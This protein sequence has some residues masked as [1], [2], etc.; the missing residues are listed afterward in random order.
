MKKMAE[1]GVVW[2]NELFE[3]GLCFDEFDFSRPGGAFKPI[4]KLD[5]PIVKRFLRALDD[6]ADE[7]Y[8]RQ[9]FSE[10]YPDDFRRIEQNSEYL[11]EEIRATAGKI[12]EFMNE[13]TVSEF[14]IV[15]AINIEPFVGY[16]AG[17]T[18]TLGRDVAVSM[19]GLLLVEDDFQTIFAFNARMMFA[20]ESLHP[21]VTR[22]MEAP[23]HEAE[24]RVLQELYPLVEAAARATGDYTEWNAYFGETITMALNIAMNGSQDL[25]VE[26]TGGEE[27]FMLVAPAVGILQREFVGK[28]VAFFDFYPT[29]VARIA[30]ILKK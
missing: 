11:I 25:R 14:R 6:L 9:Y 22:A 7:E 1:R 2:E 30:G 8:I 12:P 21:F 15:P 3:M 27:N 20:H 4:D 23:E 10:A 28:D 19:Y 5:L 16:G 13:R 26:N 24:A 17:M 29:L 18:D